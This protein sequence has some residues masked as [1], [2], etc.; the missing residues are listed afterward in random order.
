MTND[1]LGSRIK[2][3]LDDVEPSAAFRSRVE[4]QLHG[5]TTTRQWTVRWLPYS[6]AA[7]VAATVIIVA[8]ITANIDRGTNTDAQ[9]PTGVSRASD[10]GASATSP[11]IEG[12]WTLI[13]VIDG[14][15][16]MSAA[17]YPAVLE[18][19]ADAFRFTTKCAMTT[20]PY[21]M[22]ADTITF[23]GATSAAGCIE[24]RDPPVAKLREMLDLRLFEGLAHVTLNPELTTL[25]LAIHSNTMT[26]TRSS[27]P[28]DLPQSLAPMPTAGT[29]S[30]PTT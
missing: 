20:G 30:N 12:S 24:S 10:S 6:I 21:D 2:A 4:A 28:P 1:D 22:H 15:Q 9:H 19:T 3:A 25:T 26:F 18:L 29:S 7:A 8:T 14:Q 27:N 23:R 16:R 5:N 13:Y 17:P 11:N